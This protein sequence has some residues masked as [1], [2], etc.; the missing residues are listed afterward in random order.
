M[1][2][3]EHYEKAVAEYLRRLQFKG[4]SQ[5]TAKNYDSVLRKFGAY[6]ALHDGEDAD[7]L[8]SVVESWRDDLLTAGCA[9]SSVKTYLVTLNIFFGAAS[10]RS[11]PANLRYAENPVDPDF[12]PIVKK[13]PYD[14]LLPDEQVMK[15]WENSPPPHCSAT[16]P[17]NYAIVCLILGTGIRNSEL[18]NLRLS[19][20]S[21][22]D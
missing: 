19:D 4:V 3:H 1:T 13:K 7:D 18:R 12:Y 6:L 14:N 21:W 10:K 2:L 5:Q 8:Y 20:V 16:W 17:R 15:L 11:F 9:K 22:R